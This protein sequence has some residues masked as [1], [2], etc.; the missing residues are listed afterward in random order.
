MR[1]A[2]DL[3][4]F[5]DLLRATSDDADLPLWIVEKDYYVMRALRALQDKI[6]VQGWYQ[7]CKRLE[8]D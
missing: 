4:D 8:P 1:Y 7:S 6:G 5:Q 3:P 2:S